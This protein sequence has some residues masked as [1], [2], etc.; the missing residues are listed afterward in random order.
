MSNTRNSEPPISNPLLHIVLFVVSLACFAASVTQVAFTVKSIA[1]AT[2]PA[3]ISVATTANASTSAP[4][5]TQAALSQPSQP[6]GTLPVMPQTRSADGTESVSGLT[7]L[8]YGWVALK[9][10]KIAWLA[11][12]AYAVTVLCFLPRKTRKIADGASLL[13]VALAVLF[14]LTEKITI[15]GELKEIVSYGWGF[16]LWFASMLAMWLGFMMNPAWKEGAD[17]LP[18]PAPKKITAIVKTRK[19]AE[20]EPEPGSETPIATPDDWPFF[21]GKKSRDD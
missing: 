7:C 13:C 15:H 1:P 6:V 2:A 12:V 10:Y 4:A 16:Y 21:Y 19:R 8:I 9:E 14:L 20:A 11:N 3:T 18:A 17:G 5:T